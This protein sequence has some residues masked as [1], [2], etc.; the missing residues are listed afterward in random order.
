MQTLAVEIQDCFVDRFMAF[1]EKSQ[2]NIKVQ[3]DENLK[4]DGDFYQRQKQLNQTRGDIKSGKEVMKPHKEVWG[5]IYQHLS[6]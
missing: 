4:I 5:N 6:K 2:P 1:V 3:I